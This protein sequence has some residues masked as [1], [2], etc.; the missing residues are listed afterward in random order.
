MNTRSLSRGVSVGVLTAAACLAGGCAGREPTGSAETTTAGSL[1][2]NVAASGDV[3]GFLIEVLRGG[4]AIHSRFV[5]R[6]E[7]SEKTSLYVLLEPGSYQV[8]ATAMRDEN[9][10]HAGCD[11]PKANV[12][13]KASSTS[14]VELNARCRSAS[15]G[16]D[17]NARV[18]FEPQI[19]S[20]TVSPST[21]PT[22]CERV[23]V[24]AT[25][26]DADGDSLRCELVVDEQ[27][28]ELPAQ[29]GPG[30]EVQCSAG[31]E[32]PRAG[33]YSITL[34]FCDSAGCGAIDVPLHV[35]AG[36]ACTPSCDDENPCTED[37]A[38][39]QGVCAHSPVADGTLCSSGNLRVKLLGFNDFHGQLSAGRVV[40]NRPVGGAAVLASYLKNAQAGIE[41]QTI[42]V[43]AGDH[44][45]ASPPASALLQDEP[46]ITFLNLLANS[47]CSSAD[48]LN[49][50]CNIV[51]T[52]GNHEFDEGTDELLRL[53]NG[54]NF[55]QGPYLE[56]PFPGARF[57]YVSSNVLD[58]ETGESLLRPFVVKTVHGVPIGFIG[59]VLK[60]TPTIVT[61]TGVAGLEFADE[62]DAINAQVAALHTLGVHAIVVTIHQGGFQSSYTGPTRVA[63]LLTSGPEITGIVSRLHDDV[64]VVVS[65][66]S[67]AFTNVLLP[68]QN[69]KQILVTQAF[70]ASTAFDDIDLLIDPLTK[71]V[72]SKTAS[73]V[74]T[75]A[76][77]GPGLAPDPAVASLVAAAEAKVAPLV[78]RVYGTAPV[79]ITRAQS[80]A[81]ESQLGDLIADAQL[82]AMSSFGAQFVFM[83]P[84]GIRADLDAGE[85][86]FGDLFTIQP[87]GNTLVKLDMTGAEIIR[88]LEQQWLGQTSP[89]ILQIAGFDYSWDP[90]RPVGSR[91]LEVR[92]NGASIDP[93]ASYV[94]VCNNFLAT[95]G[96]G[97]TGF[98]AGR[99]QVGGPIDL[100][101]LI[102]YVEEH[103]PITL[104]NLG[105]IRTP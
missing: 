60:Q 76:D 29:V 96:D 14:Q 71:D 70:S 6:G 15:G 38:T 43:H 24:N 50:R 56:D 85:V 69:G 34:R 93:D 79:G 88:V 32:P 102:E 94:V 12:A 51:G 2:L 18:D 1:E 100:D 55:S 40:S 45:G 92:L 66:H 54:G 91:V 87:F 17:V 98:I 39:E 65:G 27:V 25:A 13:I 77:A 68:N 57:P 59:A 67:H 104:P 89:K 49:P 97:F 7:G 61:P 81:G 21:S 86:T 58:R 73:I 9:T 83:N 31:L 5:A 3:A 64:D 16:L 53:L 28:T 44:V 10:R 101:A 8:R 37:S 74:T 95:G 99:N 63:S 84:G 48:K 47:A 62:A 72:V 19:T 30:G 33:E 82:A 41:D 46:A 105:R 23:T 4:V 36:P 26:V 80:T 78:G 52:L 90:A 22:P 103:T 35:A 20:L 75:F 42:I 11:I